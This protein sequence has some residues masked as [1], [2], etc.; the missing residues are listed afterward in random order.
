MGD[1]EGGQGNPGTRRGN[2]GPV[3]VQHQPTEQG[4]EVRGLPCRVFRLKKTSRNDIKTR[5]EKTRG[6]KTRQDKVGGTIDRCMYG[7]S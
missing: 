7:T 2:Q 5:Q 6:D 1:R 4:R 3:R